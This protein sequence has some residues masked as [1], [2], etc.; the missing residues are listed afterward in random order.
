MMTMAPAATDA[1][2]LM[3]DTPIDPSVAI[4]VLVVAV[5]I[6]LF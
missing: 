3:T 5:L 4:V 1:A 6:W 2:L